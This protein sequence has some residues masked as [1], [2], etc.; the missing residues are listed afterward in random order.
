VV[1]K[2][3]WQIFLKSWLIAAASQLG[4][5]FGFPP[6][7]PTLDILLSAFPKL[8]L[9]IPWRHCLCSLRHW[10]FLPKGS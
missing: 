2:K 6:F 8:L 10:N 4:F 7:N 9:L 1:N 3:K 5:E